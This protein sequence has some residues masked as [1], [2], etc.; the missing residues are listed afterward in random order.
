[1]IG[2]MQGDSWYKARWLDISQE[3]GEDVIRKGWGSGTW[4][5]HGRNAAR[6]RWRDAD[7]VGEWQRHG[8]AVFRRYLEHS[9]DTL[10]TRLRRVADI[11]QTYQRGHQWRTKAWGQGLVKG[12]SRICQEARYDMTSDV[13]RR[14][15]QEALL[16][17]SRGVAELVGQRSRIV[18]RCSWLC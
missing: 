5:G 12:R 10:R 9:A 17:L 6:K 8:K 15:G 13:R 3:D 18:K 11:L 1:M 4:Y 2:I 7:M 14:A 16:H